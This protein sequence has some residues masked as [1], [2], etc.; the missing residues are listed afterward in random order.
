MKIAFLISNLLRS[1]YANKRQSL[2]TMGSLII[3]IVSVLLVLSLGNGVKNSISKQLDD[4]TGGE[5]T[6]TINY[7]SSAGQGGIT[8]NDAKRIEELKNIS[9]ANLGVNPLLNIVQV[10]NGVDDKKKNANYDELSEKYSK[11]DPNVHSHSGD[12]LKN[13]LAMGKTT[14]AIKDTFAQK[15]YSSKDI[16]GK[17]IE[18]K[19]ENY[20]ISSLYTGAEETPDILMSPKVYEQFKE[21]SPQFNQVK[22][23]YKGNKVE[24][25]KLVLNYLSKHGEFNYDGNYE[26]E[27]V[28]QVVNQINKTTSLATNL[29]AGVAGISLV[30]AGFGVM[31]STYSS[32]AERT[33]EIGLRR[34]FGARKSQIR[35]QFML[36]GLFMTTISSV[37]SLALVESLSIFLGDSMGIRLIITGSN[38]L[39]SVVVPAAIGLI[40]T[41][42]P[43]VSASNKNV[44]TL[45]R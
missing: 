22:I 16:L 35:N 40:F 11:Q 41:Y 18:I 8:E 6:F 44:L 29:I 23:T 31:S 34:A 10:S 14:V 21:Y 28:H 33:S 2:L 24:A 5:N 19:G 15:L 30:V 9:N 39:V 43:A 1:L 3:G 42:F 20:V 25:K 13:I 4:V 27:D 37:L 12:S 17:T 36:E 45:L 32:I 7:V 38:I 26:L